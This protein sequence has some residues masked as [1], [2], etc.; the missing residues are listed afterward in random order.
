MVG[1]A[2]SDIREGGAC[3]AL[4]SAHRRWRRDPD[5]PSHA[6]ADAALSG[7]P[8][9]PSTRHRVALS[10]CRSPCPAPPPEPASRTPTGAGASPQPPPFPL[11]VTLRTPRGGAGPM[12]QGDIVA[13]GHLTLLNNQPNCPAYKLSDVST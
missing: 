7:C 11:T 13:L 8:A 5:W 1:F 6:A 4:P 9:R 10:R 2:R 12:R 3:S